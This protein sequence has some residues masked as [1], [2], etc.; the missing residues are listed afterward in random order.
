MLKVNLKVTGCVFLAVAAT[1]LSIDLKPAQALTLN[2][3]LGIAGNGVVNET[4]DSVVAGTAGDQTKLSFLNPLSV[5]SVAGDFA[6]PNINPALLGSSPTIKNLVLTD[7]DGDLLYDNPGVTNFIDFGSY[8]INSVT[9][10]LSFDLDS[11]AEEFARHQV[12]NS[13]SYQ[14]PTGIFGEFKFNGNTLA[15]GFMNISQSR[16]TGAFQI[17]L[18]TKAVPEPSNLLGFGVVAGLIALMKNGKK[19]SVSKN[20]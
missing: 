1:V 19:A 15:D 6:I 9:A 13:I 4:F 14:D 8:T 16:Q 18:Q 20:V 11:G 7:T 2:G 5:V 12:G 17:S 10:N 3:S